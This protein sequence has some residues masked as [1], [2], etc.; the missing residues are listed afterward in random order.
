MLVR[1]KGDVKVKN[2]FNS[3]LVPVCGT[4]GGG[5]GGGGGVLPLCGTPKGMCYSF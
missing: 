5:E 2:L 4:S 3:N 1:Y